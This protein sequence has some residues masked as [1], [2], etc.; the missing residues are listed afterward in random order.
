MKKFIIIALIA[1]SALAAAATIKEVNTK[2]EVKTQ[3][4]TETVE[5]PRTAVVSNWD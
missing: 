4:P 5:T 2:E 1:V 3:L